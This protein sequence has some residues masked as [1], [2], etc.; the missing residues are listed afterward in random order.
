[1]FSTKRHGTFCCTFSFDEA[2]GFV[3][4]ENLPPLMSLTLHSRDVLELTV[5]KTFIGVLVTTL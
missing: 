1:L 2:D 3:V 5:T 4:P